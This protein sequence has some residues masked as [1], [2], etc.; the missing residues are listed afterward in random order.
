VQPH[1]V[2]LIADTFELGPE[3]VGVVD[4][5]EVRL[6]E[7][8]AQD[9]TGRHGAAR[10]L[11]AGRTV[12]RQAVCG[13]G[14]RR[15]GPQPRQQR[16][17][18]LAGFAAGQSRIGAPIHAVLRAAERVWPRRHTVASTCRMAYGFVFTR[19]CEYWGPD[20][21]SGRLVAREQ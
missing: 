6:E 7:R 13:P 15:S 8:E 9:C 17:F 11:D 5:L 10:P 1:A 2:V 21:G 18:P 20:G 12:R 19:R 16:G 4:V 3:N 14:T